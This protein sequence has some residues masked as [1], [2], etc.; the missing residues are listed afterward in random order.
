L[1]SAE[2]K[3]TW[4]EIEQIP[5]KKK[6]APKPKEEKKE[7]P[8]PAEGEQ[9]P[10]EGEQKPAEGEQKPAEGEEKPA[11]GEE[12]PAAEEKPAEEAAAPTPPPVEESVIEY[13]KK[14][15]IRSTIHSVGVD[16]SSHAI[17]P[18]VKQQLRDIEKNLY[19]DDLRFLS[20]K[21]CRND[22][23]AYSYEMRNNLED[24]G[25]Y[26]KFCEPTIRTQFLAEI[27]TTI[28]W[29]YDAGEN[30]PLCDY[31]TKMAKFREIGEAIIKR[32]RFYEALPDTKNAY[33]KMVEK[34]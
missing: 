30:A 16:T 22:L 21:K 27:G 24:Y 29:L 32:Y 1:Q 20:W 3:E 11:E 12:K 19:K 7:E 18:N 9:K 14:E 23:E 34:A 33:N 4:T 25:S 13:E 26:V 2:L 31:E 8:K 17:P 15:R 28:E 6:V 5:I 10:A